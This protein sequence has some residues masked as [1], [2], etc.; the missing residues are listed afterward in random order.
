MMILWRKILTS[1]LLLCLIGV[2]FASVR[3][4]ILLLKSSLLPHLVPR[5]LP[6]EL[7]EYPLSQVVYESCDH[8]WGQHSSFQKAPWHVEKAYSW[9]IPSFTQKTYLSLV[10]K[11]ELLYPVL[12]RNPSSLRFFWEPEPLYFRKSRD[13]YKYHLIGHAEIYSLGQQ[14]RLKVSL[15]LQTSH[16]AINFQEVLPYQ[17]W[18]IIDNPYLTALIHLEKFS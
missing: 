8:R 14:Q 9:V 15:C 11:Q 7:K 12:P 5:E 6:Y 13:F 18:V 3:V 10:A 2:S 17:E 1:S 16:G 4:D